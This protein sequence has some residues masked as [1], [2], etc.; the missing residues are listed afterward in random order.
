MSYLQIYPLIVPEGGTDA[1]SFTTYAVI[2]GGTTSTGSLQSI[3]SVGTSG[4]VLTST[5]SSSLPTFQAAAT[6]DTNVVFMTE[7]S[8]PASPTNADVWFNTT[9]NSFKGYKNS[10]TVTFTVT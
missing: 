4:H 8:D 9:S 1:T 10:T 6:L 7:S 3:A 2:C 5:G